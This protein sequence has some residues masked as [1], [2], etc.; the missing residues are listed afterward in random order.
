MRYVADLI[1]TY[2]DYWL[3]VLLQQLTVENGERFLRQKLSVVLERAG[4]SGADNSMRGVAESIGQWLDDKGLYSIRG[5][6][7]PYRDLMIWKYHEEMEYE[8]RLPLGDIHVEVVFMNE[9][10]ELGLELVP[11]REAIEMLTVSAR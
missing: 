4:R 5:V 3:R 6:T 10:L 1:S 9:F 8:V 7:Q 2:H 11:S